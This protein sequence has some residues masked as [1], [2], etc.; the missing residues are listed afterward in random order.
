MKIGGEFE[1]S[2]QRERG[3]SLGT[4]LGRRYR[5]T[6]YF[7]SGRAALYSVLRVLVSEH[8][9]RH[10]VLP[11]YGCSATYEAAQYAIRDFSCTL[12]VYLQ[13][14]DLSSA[15]PIAYDNAVYIATDYFGRFDQALWHQLISIR[16]SQNRVFLI[17]DR[18]QSLL[19]DTAGNDADYEVGSLRK[20]AYL[21]DGGFV[22]SQRWHVPLPQRVADAAIVLARQ[23]A[24]LIKAAKALGALSGFSDSCYLDVFHAC[25]DQWSG[26]M[27]S[28]ISDPSRSLV[29]SL[30][31]QA[32]A[33][34][35]ERNCDALVD[36]LGELPPSIGVYPSRFGCALVLR[37]ASVRN[38]LR[39]ALKTKGVYAAVHWPL[40]W[41][42][43]LDVNAYGAVVDLEQREL[44]LPVDQR[45]SADE[46]VRVGALVREELLR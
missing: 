23:G 14:S 26:H 28:S 25:E 4:L 32:V 31:W 44:T 42:K 21:P 12:H 27:M 16:S 19:D 20:W 17:R 24:S 5:E 35:R 9:V 30:A 7:M 2:E 22:G 39:Q 36:S 11:A 29:D 18:T 6:V 1:Y 40:D 45:Y 3:E 43:S 38:R 34:S 8:G 37:E 46:M 41:L 13:A 15:N 33:F 10:I